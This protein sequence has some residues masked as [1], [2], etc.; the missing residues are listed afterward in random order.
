MHFWGFLRNFFAWA[1]VLFTGAIMPTGLAGN[2][3]FPLFALPPFQVLPGLAVPHIAVLLATFSDCLAGP[4]RGKDVVAS[5]NL[6]VA[7]I[8]GRTDNLNFGKDEAG[9]RC[10]YGIEHA[11]ADKGVL[12]GVGGGHPCICLLFNIGDDRGPVA[13]RDWTVQHAN[14][15]HLLRTP[16]QVYID[17]LTWLAVPSA[18][19]FVDPGVGIVPGFCTR[20]LFLHAFHPRTKRL[21][22][23]AFRDRFF[24]SAFLVRASPGG[25]ET[26]IL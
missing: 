17:V 11:V 7:R 6:A 19:T 5:L 13:L 15:K 18:Q 24:K 20:K 10:V 9:H 8:V 12:G 25:I 21:V 4:G 16:L 26:A 3:V 14:L 23:F 1:A 22:P 2:F